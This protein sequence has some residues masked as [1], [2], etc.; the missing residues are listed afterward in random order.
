ML[1]RT[2]RMTCPACGAEPDRIVLIPQEIISCPGCGLET[3]AHE[4]QTHGAVPE[5][6]TG[7]ISVAGGASSCGDFHWRI[8]AAGNAGLAMGFWGLWCVAAF[9]LS[10]FVGFRTFPDHGAG[11][12]LLLLSFPLPLLV[13]GAVFLLQAIVRHHAEHEVLLTEDTLEIR[14]N[15]LGRVKLTVFPRPGIRHICRMAAGKGADRKHEVIEIRAGKQRVRFGGH[16]SPEERDKL[17]LEMRLRVFGTPVPV[18]GAVPGPVPLPGA[19]SFLILHRKL[20]ELPFACAAM[21]MG[22]LFMVVVLRFMSF[23]FGMGPP[24]EPMFFRVI[25]GVANTVGSVMRGVILLIALA[26]IGGGLWLWIH[27]LRIH[28]RQ[29]SL[30][31]NASQLIVRR[32]DKRGRPIR[33]KTYPRDASTSIRTSMQSITGGVTLKRIELLQGEEATTLISDVRSEEAE[34]ILKSLS[35]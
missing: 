21:A 19:F 5:A 27:S 29:T 28:L 15:L 22:A 6:A 30:E 11:S 16:L 14:R 24:G 20:H 35:E 13:I 7:R 23:E 25:E 3:S 1:R 17:V 8:P 26:M 18:P 33:E 12:L 34:A 31:G 9:A 32:F 10:G 4:W 2:H